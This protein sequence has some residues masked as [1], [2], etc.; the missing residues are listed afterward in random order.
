MAANLKDRVRSLLAN[1]QF[2]DPTIAVTWDGPR[3]VASIV[4]SSF[5]GINEAERQA[6][7]WDL[8]AAN[9]SEEDHRRIAFVFTDVPSRQ[10]A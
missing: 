4:T 8:L 2:A 3:L 9:L 10:V 5:E 6:L 1:A 7:I